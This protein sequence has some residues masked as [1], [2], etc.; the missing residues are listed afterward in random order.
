MEEYKRS[1][2][3]Y[4]YYLPDN[5]EE[6][7]DHRNGFKYKRVIEDILADLRKE[8]KYGEDTPVAPSDLRQKIFNLLEE[9]EVLGDF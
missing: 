1:E 3:I 5:E 8:A 6:E 7:R 9:Y 2:V 4:K